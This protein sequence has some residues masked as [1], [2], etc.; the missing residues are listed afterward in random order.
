MAE[1]EAAVEG[2]TID[3]HTVVVQ[4]GIVYIDGVQATL[5]RTDVNVFDVLTQFFDHLNA[6]TARNFLAGDEARKEEVVDK[7][8]PVKDGVEI[9]HIPGEPSST[10]II[11]VGR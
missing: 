10:I 5:G 7:G 6:E 8:S 3:G 2:H 11:N 9:H 1:I 4:D